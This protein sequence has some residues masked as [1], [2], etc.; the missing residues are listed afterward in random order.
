MFKFRGSTVLEFVLPANEMIPANV[1]PDVRVLHRATKPSHHRQFTIQCCHPADHQLAGKHSQQ[2]RAFCLWTHPT[3]A[4]LSEGGCTG[5]RVTSCLSVCLDTAFTP[6]RVQVEAYDWMTRRICH[7]TSTFGP[8]INL[9][10]WMCEWVVT[11][12]GV[13]VHNKY[14]N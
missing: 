8:N 12:E 6:R 1:S 2:D 7:V 14:H 9:N 5:A 4:H 3:H 11:I 10:W 13:L